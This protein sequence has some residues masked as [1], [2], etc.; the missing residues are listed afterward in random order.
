M[1][2]IELTKGHRHNTGIAKEIQH[3]TLR[4]TINETNAAVKSP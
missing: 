2:L 4:S 3:V 1:S